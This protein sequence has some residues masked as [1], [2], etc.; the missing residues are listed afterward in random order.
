M[1]STKPVRWDRESKRPEWPY[2]AGPCWCGVPFHIARKFVYFFYL[3]VEEMCLCL[4][5]SSKIR[6]VGGDNLR[7]C[8]ISVSKQWSQGQSLRLAMGQLTLTKYQ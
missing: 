6:T 4:G 2:G 7:T 8:S 3:R 1:G 5:S